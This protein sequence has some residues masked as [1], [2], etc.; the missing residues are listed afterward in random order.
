MRSKA[1][2]VAQYLKELP[3]DRR[4]ALQA[5]R[6]VI[7]KSKD[8]LIEEGMQY[9]AI[10]YYIP[11]KVFPPGYHCD[12]KQPL[13]Y[14]GLAAQKNHL[15]LYLMCLYMEAPGVA[16]SPL[17]WFRQA[18][19][20]AGKKLDMGASCVRFRNI[21][22]VPLDVVAKLFKK[23]TA[24]QFIA[25]YQAACAPRIAKV[26]GKAP[27]KAPAGAKPGSKK[28]VAKKVAAK[29]PAAKKPAAKKPAAKKPA[30]R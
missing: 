11:H 30:A 24:R 1:T 28:P 6:E 23:V 15:G 27:A 18:W 12:P 3:A 8:P 5:L 21:E 19:T 29:K 10:G 17:P 9:G 13:P 7:L 22:D 4:A 26:R 16:D 2:S 14:A 25:V 20:A